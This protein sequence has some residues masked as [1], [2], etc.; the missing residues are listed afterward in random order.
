MNGI[1]QKDDFVVC[2]QP[3]DIFIFDVV[4]RQSGLK[5]PCSRDATCCVSFGWEAGILTKRSVNH[6][7]V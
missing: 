6:E 2:E 1:P 4:W 3:H 7:A 5:A